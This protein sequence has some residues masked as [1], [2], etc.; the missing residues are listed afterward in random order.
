[1]TDTLPTLVLLIGP[2]QCGKTTHA[3]LGANRGPIVNPDAIRLALHG[4]PYIQSAEPFV[5]AIARTM[6]KALFKAG[7]RRV[8]LD[9]CNNTKK[10]RDEWLSRSWRREF[11]VLWDPMDRDAGREVLEQRAIVNRK[12]HLLSVIERMVDQHE[13]VSQEEIDRG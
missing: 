3:L 6:V 11:V 1:M 9:A 4:Q 13:P 5:W 12:P 7:H 8:I 10:R 2:P